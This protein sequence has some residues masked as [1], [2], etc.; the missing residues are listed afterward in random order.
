MQTLTGTTTTDPT[1]T[2][3]LSCVVDGDTGNAANLAVTPLQ[4]VLNAIGW[5]RANVALLS[6]ATFTGAVNVPASGAGTSNAA[7]RSELDS[8]I[9]SEA[10][11]RSTGDSNTL[12]SANS[13]TD[14]L[15]SIMSGKVGSGSNPGITNSKGAAFT[16]ASDGQ[17]SRKIMNANIT[18]NT[19]ATAVISDGSVGFITTACYSG[20]ILVGC[21]NPSQTVIYPGFSFI[22]TKF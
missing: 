18:V 3:Q 6:G 4:F 7:R 10:T 1:T 14:G 17:Y 9:S 8:A 2:P 21:E 20:Y 11:S 12:A 5:L 22:V 16:V 13:Y 15:S 19:I